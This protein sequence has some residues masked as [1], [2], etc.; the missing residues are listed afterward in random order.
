MG[1]NR[2]EERAEANAVILARLD[3]R[4]K[5]MAHDMAE[6]KRLNTDEHEEIKKSLAEGYVSKAD[7]RPVKQIVFGAVGLVLTSVFAGLIAL[8]V[9]EKP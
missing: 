4:L 2:G 8:V 6:M 7:F 3:E 9:K 5:A 1:E